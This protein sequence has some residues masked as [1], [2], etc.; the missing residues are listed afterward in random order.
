MKEPL[1]EFER[2]SDASRRAGVEQNRRSPTTRLQAVLFALFLGT[3]GAA[4]LRYGRFTDGT[5]GPWWAFILMGSVCGTLGY[6]VIRWGRE[7]EKAKQG[8]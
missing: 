6:V 2:I 3:A 7:A 8:R 4:M 1:N 5:T